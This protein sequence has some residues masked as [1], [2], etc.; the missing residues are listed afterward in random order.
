MP[1]RRL[2]RWT[3]AL[4]VALAV[5]TGCGSGEPAATSTAS[6]S[7]PAAGGAAA[8]VTVFAAASLTGTFTKLGEAFEAAHPGVT[9]RFNF[10]SS[11]TLAQQITQ[12]APADV[13]AAASPATMK[14]VTDAGLAASP[15]VFVRN[16]LQI[17]VPA[18][19]PAGVD[20]LKDLADAK[21]KVA[22]CAAQVP[23]GAAAVKALDAA[24]LKVTPVTLEQD[25]KAALTKVGLGEVDAALV[26]ITD[27]LASGGKVRGIDFPE[28]G[29]SIN[30]YPIAALTEAPAGPAAQRFVDLVLS[31]QGR[32]V[33]TEAGFQAP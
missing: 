3:I 13:F 20:E 7:A 15:T 9:V 24:G 33:L 2:P 8:E 6:G 26:Y 14:T 17:A 12:G 25:V 11:A 27:V 21:V 29:E 22:L 4:P 23:C 19:N 18:G 1:L 16:R 30:D 31:P 10:G 32:D 28:A 5:L